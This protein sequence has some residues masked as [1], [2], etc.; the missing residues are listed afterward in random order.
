LNHEK[1]IEA[2]KLKTEKG[3]WR[4][5]DGFY[6]NWFSKE[7]DDK[8]IHE[9]TIDDIQSV[10]NKALAAG[11]RPATAKYMKAFIRQLFNFA[12]DREFYDKDNITH[13][14]TTPSFDNRRTRYYT[15]EEIKKIL[16]ALKKR[17]VQIHNIALFAM[18]TGCRPIE[19]FSLSWS[20]VDFN[21]D[22][23]TVFDT[24]NNKTKHVPI[25]DEVKNLLARLKQEDSQ[26]LIFK[27]RKG[28]QIKSAS[29]V[30]RDVLKTLGINEGITDDRQKGVFYT[31]RHSYASW[32]MMKGADLYDVKEL[33]GHS[34]TAMTERYSH[35]SPE[36]LKKTAM[37]LN[38]Y[39]VN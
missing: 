8:K 6:R 27:S 20:N 26:G 31:L 28:T 11:R 37:L 36:H 3:S 33:M 19:I 17:S 16:A 23:I 7:L 15:I 1:Y 25:V 35:L 32:L 14:V 2:Q 30:F 18:Y 38:K 12:K 34:T 24:K 21:N 5:E 29:K 4:T 39:K 13:K 10:I 9:I 22:V